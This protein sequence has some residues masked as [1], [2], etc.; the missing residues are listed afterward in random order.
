MGFVYGDPIELQADYFA[1]GLSMPS[2]PFA[3]EAGQYSDGLSAIE[4][5]AEVCKTS[6]T[7]STIRSADATD[8]A[9][10]TRAGAARRSV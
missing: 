8:A 7:A 2:S 9:I 6:L 10:F 5:L 1:A 4:N 3:K